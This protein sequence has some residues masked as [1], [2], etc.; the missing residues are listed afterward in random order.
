MPG[1][2]G[3]VGQHVGFARAH[4]GGQFRP[5]R[6]ELLGDMLPALDSSFLVGLMEGLRD[7]TDTTVCCPFG[8]WASALRIQCTRQRCQVAS[9]TR[10]IAS[11]R[12]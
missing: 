10:R 7:A 3:H 11:V 1:R 4:Q 12:S 5:A 6:A 9:N 2:E 8:T